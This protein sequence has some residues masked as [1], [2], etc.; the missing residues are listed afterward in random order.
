MPADWFSYWRLNCR[1]A[2]YHAWRTGAEGYKMEDKFSFLSKG[3]E[4]D[5]PVSPIMEVPQIV[6]KHRNE[7]GGLGIYFYGNAL[8]GGDWIIQERLHNDDFVSS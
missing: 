4:L 5:V 6:V 8:S 3:R 7:E 1:L 2:S